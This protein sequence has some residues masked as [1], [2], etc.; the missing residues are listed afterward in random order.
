MNHQQLDQ[1][2]DELKSYTGKW[3]NC[4]V[5]KRGVF[6]GT[7]FYDS[8]QEARESG[9]KKASLL[10]EKYRDG[11]AKIMNGEKFFFMWSDFICHIQIPAGE[12]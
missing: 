10:N 2:V 7:V 8:E 12:L 9:I 1:Q 4:V 5:T 6:N 3:I 11:D